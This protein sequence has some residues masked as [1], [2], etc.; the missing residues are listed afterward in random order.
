MEGVGA[1]KALV[2]RVIAEL[3]RGNLAIDDETIAEDFIQNGQPVGR[4]GVKAGH[5]RAWTA[6]PDLTITIEQ[7]IAEG[8][9]VAL[10]GIYEGTHRGE[11]GLPGVGTLPPT[12]KRFRYAATA[13][14][15]IADGKLAEEW[16][17]RDTLAMAL[18]LGA[19]IVPPPTGAATHD[20][21]R[22]SNLRRT[23][24]SRG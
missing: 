20:E 11:V 12:G 13:F 2:R 10:R 1:N 8:D 18:Q 21:G 15:R 5:A 22:G 24:V 4:A 19:R 6:F 9:T 23:E 14:I 3:S 17:V 7:L 16:G